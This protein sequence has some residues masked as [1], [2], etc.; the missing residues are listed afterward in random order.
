MLSAE[1][2]V[3]M[4]NVLTEAN[5]GRPVWILPVRIVDH[6]DGTSQKLPKAK[7]AEAEA[8]PAGVQRLWEKKSNGYVGVHLARSGLV[9]ADQD[10]DE[11]PH[12]LHVLL[13]EHPTFTS[14]S[15]RRSLPHYWYRQP[16]PSAQPRDRKWMYRGTHVGDLKSKGI[17]VIG[18]IVHDIPFAQLPD[19]LH[20][21]HGSGEPVAEGN[22]RLLVRAWLNW[23]DEPPPLSESLE[24]VRYSLTELE[25]AQPGERNNALYRAARDVAQVT[26]AGAITPEEAATVLIRTAEHVFNYE[27]LRGEVRA[28]I[29]SAFERERRSVE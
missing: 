22:L 15:L 23:L 26:A 28:T 16:D 29:E 8:T 17:G 21:F 4:L 13:D 18:R 14:E 3:T 19:E 12:E 11:I 1:Q 24:W 25:Q 10:F 6:A 20:A 2:A 7:W 27:E 9:L 5:Q